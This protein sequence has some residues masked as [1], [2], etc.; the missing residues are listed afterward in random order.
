MASE[1]IREN[2][3]FFPKLTLLKPEFTLGDSRFDFYAE[4]EDNDGQHHKMLIEVKG[5]T[6]EKDG[7]ALFPDAP[8]LRGLKHVRVLPFLTDPSVIV[9]LR[10]RS[11]I[12]VFFYRKSS[13]PFAMERLYYNFPVN[14]AIVLRAVSGFFS[15]LVNSA[16]AS[17]VPPFFAISEAMISRHFFEFPPALE[18]KAQHF[19]P[20][21][22]TLSKKVL[23]GAAGFAA[24]TGAPM[25]ILS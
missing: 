23:R 19:L 15:G 14:S 24:Q 17:T 1:W 3:T 8:T 10:E 9:F 12:L 25:M 20:E 7:V 21:R 2:K 13:S 16:Q 11:G 6:L 5:C 4:Y 22:F 18:A